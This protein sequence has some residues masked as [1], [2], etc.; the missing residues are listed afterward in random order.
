MAKYAGEIILNDDS[1]VYF[2]DDGFDE[3]DDYMIA[4]Q[5]QM[6]MDEENDCVY[7]QEGGG[8][9]VKKEGE[10]SSQPFQ[11]FDSKYELLDPQWELIDPSPDIR[12]MFQ[13][14][15]KKYFGTRWAVVWS[16]GG[17]LFFFNI[18]FYVQSFLF[19]CS[20]YLNLKSLTEL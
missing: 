14:F 11:Q 19:F 9:I 16:N 10:K 2:L 13:E 6:Q 15:D 20:T 5:M 3:N 7:D 12:A 17:W 4:L 18:L 8:K 1:D